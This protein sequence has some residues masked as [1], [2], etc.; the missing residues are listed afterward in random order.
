M[1]P[2]SLRLNVRVFSVFL[3][4]GLLML[5]TASYFVLG[6]GQAR[7]RD[8]WGSH[9]RQVADQTAASVDT[10]VYRLII[11]ASV[12]ARVPSVRAEATTASQRPF[13]EAAAQQVART[14]GRPNAPAEAKAILTQPVS[15]FLAEMVSQNPIYRDLLLTDRYGRVVAASDPSAGY[16]QSREA[17]WSATVGDGVRGQLQVSDVRLQQQAK[18][19]G[20]EISVPVESSTGGS[21]AGVLRAVIDVREVGAVLGGVRMGNTGD[22]ALL[23][24]DGSFVFPTRTLDANARFF[25]ADLLRER[26]TMA[27]NGSPPAVLQFGAS[28]TNGEARL[29]GVAM[30]QL[31]ASYP[32]LS[33]VVAVSQA[34]D[35][36][37]APVRAQAASLIIVM[38]FTTI[39]VLLFAFW[40]SV[41]LA[42]P[43]EPEEMNLHLV[44]HPRVHRIEEPEDADQEMAETV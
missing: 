14:W 10:Y 16:L 31:K 40:Y 7:L 22:A 32:N 26:L 33:W 9:L 28:S 20:I 41:K 35:E 34:D 21:L 23:R 42:A 19:W 15:M 36:L 5:V 11:D 27:K 13:D 6:I 25:A 3:V 2:A 1:R 18:V 44:R 17:W 38:A 30:S 37:F 4:V 43:S 12:L 24:E 29:V 39:A 8:S